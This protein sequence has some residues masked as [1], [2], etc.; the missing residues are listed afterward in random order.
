MRS[1]RSL[2]AVLALGALWFPV[3]AQAGTITGRVTD[4]ISGTPLVDVT[5]GVGPVGYGS[6]DYTGTAADGTWAIDEPDA[7]RYTACFFPDPHVVNLLWRCWRDENVGFYGEPID[8][9]ESGTVDGIDTTLAPGTSITGT[10]TDW[11]GNRRPGVCV[12]AWTP[13]SGM[14]RVADDTTAADGT[15]TLVGLTPRAVNKVVFAPMSSFE[16][17]CVGGI[18]Y[19]GDDVSQWFDRGADFGSARSLTAEAGETLAGIDGMVG[20][21]VVPAG[22]PPPPPPCI[23]PTLRNRTYRS[24]W[25]K[26]AQAGCSILMPKLQRSRAFRRGRLITSRPAAKPRLRRGRPVRLTVSRGR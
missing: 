10:V 3:M 14:L 5:V 23:V 15:Y 18:D 1:F 7:G 19:P 12:S 21:S 9:P 24:A 26:L 13:H 11:A 20:P 17:H 16:G 6:R 22:R 8:V 2:T 4:L 25:A